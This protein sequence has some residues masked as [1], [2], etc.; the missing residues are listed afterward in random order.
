[1][2][3]KYNLNVS[4]AIITFWTSSADENCNRQVEICPKEMISGC[5]SV[6]CR[7]IVTANPK[8]GQYGHELLYLMYTNVDPSE[9]S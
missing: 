9:L 6:K 2:I 4:T 8:R 3:S 1:M 5:I 7:R